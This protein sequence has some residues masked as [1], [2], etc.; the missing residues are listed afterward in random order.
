MLESNRALAQGC[1]TA[2]QQAVLD[3]LREAAGAPLTLGEIARLASARLPQPQR[4]QL[5]C[6]EDVACILATLRLR[7]GFRR[8]I[9][10]H[11]GV[12][13][14]SPYRTAQQAG[15]QSGHEGREEARKW[16]PSAVLASARTEAASR[17]W[18]LSLPVLAATGL[19]AGCTVLPAQHP[20]V[21]TAPVTY[22]PGGVVAKTEVPRSFRPFDASTVTTCSG[23]WGCSGPHLEA[24]AESTKTPLVGPLAYHAD[25]YAEHFA[26]VSPRMRAWLNAPHDTPSSAEQAAAGVSTGAAPSA[27]LAAAPTV[28]LAGA[29]G[30]GPLAREPVWTGA[31]PTSGSGLRLGGNVP[32]A[33]WSHSAS[34]SKGSGAASPAIPQSGREWVAEQLARIDPTLPELHA[35]SGPTVQA[36]AIARAYPQQARRPAELVE[37]SGSHLV[38]AFDSGS[39]RITPRMREALRHVAGSLHAQEELQLRG[40]VGFRNPGAVGR[41]LAVNRANA[42]RAELVALGVPAARII[43]AEPRDGDLLASDF[44]SP[45]NRSVSMLRVQPTKVAMRPSTRPTG[46]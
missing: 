12:V 18:P 30:A 21:F 28:A 36:A 19:V 1:C 14:S 33:L 22:F 35:H 27:A 39:Q 46:G 23:G 40:R 8:A 9:R 44:D 17:P 43:V 34:A 25:G 26:Q 11:P 15:K 29:S 3:V 41:A 38:V 10:K 20:L 4:K 5:C 45:L 31:P 42:V 37:V 2:E 16:R 13:P 7:E 32:S 6:E 24:V